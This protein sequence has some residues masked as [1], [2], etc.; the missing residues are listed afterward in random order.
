MQLQ[1]Q[2]GTW[3]LLLALLSLSFAVDGAHSHRG[4]RSRLEEDV[5]PTCLTY[6]IGIGTQKGGTTAAWAYLRDKA[7]PMIQAYSN[8]KEVGFFDQPGLEGKQQLQV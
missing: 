5:S 3:T 6:L 2:R 1:M 7:H 8:E 4:L